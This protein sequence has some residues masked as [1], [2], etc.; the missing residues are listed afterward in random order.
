MFFDTLERLESWSN[1][2]YGLDP[3]RL[4]REQEFRAPLLNRLLLGVGALAI[5]YLVLGLAGV[6]S[7]RF[8]PY[9]AI[10]LLL[11][12]SVCAWLV[13]R[14]KTSTALVLP[15][16]IYSHF[17]SSVITYYGIDSPAPALL[18]PSLLVCGLFVG[19]YF[20]LTWTVICGVLIIYLGWGHAQFRWSAGLVRPIL[21]WCLMLAVVGWLVR[22]FATHLENLLHRHAG[23]VE[24]RNRISRDIHDTLAQGFTGVIVQLNAAEQVLSGDPARARE[25]MAAARELA[26]ESLQEARCSVWA[27][28]PMTLEREELGQVLERSGRSLTAATGIEFT[29]EKSADAFFLSPETEWD[30]LRIGL[31]AVTNAVRHSGCRRI[32]LRLNQV[33]GALRLE[34]EDDGK[35]GLVMNGSALR[36]GGLGLVGMQERAAR[37]GGQLEI[38]SPVGGP[39]RIRLGIPS[40]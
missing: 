7:G 18:L 27:L 3:V 12:A 39:T 2:L 5:V 36:A 38:D 37:A 1:R 10:E 6:V 4:R 9:D 8:F 34:V 25:H 20:L 40:K 19:G 35:G 15:L 11:A 13:K 28:R 24:D 32:T 21:L 16:V 17:A 29:I 33:D 26:R 30:V 14:G 22:L 31:E 23:L